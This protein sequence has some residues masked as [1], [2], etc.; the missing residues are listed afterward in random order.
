MAS[1]SSNEST[2]K[3]RSALQ[4]TKLQTKLEKLRSDIIGEGVGYMTPFGERKLVYADYTAS[5]RSLYSIENYIHNTVLPFY[6]NVHSEASM[7]GKVTTQLREEARELL[8]HCLGA[9][10]ETDVILWTGTGSTAA[11]DKIIRVMGLQRPSRGTLSGDGYLHEGPRPV[12]FLGPYE[13]HSN[14]LPWRESI[15]ECVQ[16]GLDKDDQIDLV[17][18]EQELIKYQD[19]PLKIGTFSAASN[20][21]GI[22]SDI[23]AIAVLLHKYRALAF[24]DFA[25]AAPYL[26][27]RIKASAPNA[28]DYKDAVFLSPHK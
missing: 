26:T 28:L 6:G 5:G 12:V 11:I 15:C 3:K 4:T 17:Q 9:E 25:A 1:S 18:L 20:V 27:I 24:F 23:D 2:N 21:T 10:K 8:Y 16:I 19:L 14:L 13:H 7:T 22:V